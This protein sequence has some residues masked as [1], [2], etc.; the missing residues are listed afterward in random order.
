MKTFVFKQT[1]E[2]YLHIDA[3]TAEEAQA[4]ADETEYYADNVYATDDCEWELAKVS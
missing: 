2:Y 3:E 1:Q 4:I